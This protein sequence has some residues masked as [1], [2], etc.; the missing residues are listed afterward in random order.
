MEAAAKQKLQDDRKADQLAKE[1]AA[2]T[3]EGAKR[4]GSYIPPN[5]RRGAEELLFS[6]PLHAQARRNSSIFMPPELRC[7]NTGC[8]RNT[9]SPSQ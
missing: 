7:W 5:R 1:V 6:F 2:A 4:N 8:I 9:S 3:E